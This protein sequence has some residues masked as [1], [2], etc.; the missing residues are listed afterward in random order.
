MRTC[1]MMT[2]IYFSLGKK[3]IV[4]SMEEMHLVK[5]LVWSE[6]PNP[7]HHLHVRVIT[8]VSLKPLSLAGEGEH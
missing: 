6:A 8:F 4:T 2:Q 7:E 5:H 1:W 3:A